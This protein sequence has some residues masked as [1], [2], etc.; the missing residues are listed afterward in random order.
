M[1]LEENLLNKKNNEDEIGEKNNI[2]N[3]SNDNS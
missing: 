2:I 3:N 1:T